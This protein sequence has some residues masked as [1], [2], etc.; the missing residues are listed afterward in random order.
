MNPSYEDVNQFKEW[1]MSQVIDFNLSEWKQIKGML[2]Y[3]RVREHKELIRSGEQ[4]TQ[5]RFIVSGCTISRSVHPIKNGE[6]EEQHINLI[7]SRNH[8]ASDLVSFKTVSPSIF[9]I[10]TVQSTAYLY[11]NKHLYASQL[12]HNQLFQDIIFYGIRQTENDLT[13]MI[14]IQQH[15]KAKDRL[16]L[17]KSTHPYIWKY[18]KKQEI[19]EIIN[20][21]PQTLCRLNREERG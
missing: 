11:I 15:L 14:A 3:K 8:I 13:N 2:R 19:A 17:L 10:K 12:K 20:I 9:S 7:L 5:L 6:A 21:T 4:E 16:D 18:L 1:I